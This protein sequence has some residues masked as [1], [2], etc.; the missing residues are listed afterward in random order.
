M[1]RRYIESALK[2][3]P[4]AHRKM[5]F[6]S[7]PRQCG[8]TTLGKMLLKDPGIGAYYNW[9]ETEFRRL[10][11]KSPK[12]VLPSG[13]TGESYRIVP[14]LVLDE[15]HKAKKWKQTLKGIYDTMDQ[16]A[17]ILV[18][19]SAR[20]SIYRKESDSLMGRYYHCRLHPLAL[21]LIKHPN[22]RSQHQ[23]GNTTLLVASA[24]RILP[25]FV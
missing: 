19:G 10:W 6:V 17:D 1:L 21:Q 11:T 20:L 7:G 8:K 22:Y 12:S 16:P 3:L 25:L 2:T 5:A 24:S 9:D 4:F 15:I 14:L 23:I 13:R 18:T